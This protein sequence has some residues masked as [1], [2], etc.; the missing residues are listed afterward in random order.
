VVFYLNHSLEHLMQRRD[1]LVSAGAVSAL[2][3]GSARA[4]LETAKLVV[5]YAP[6]TATDGLA[7]TL[8]ERMRGSY[9]GNFVVENKVG[10]SGQMA[11]TAV[12]SAQ[13]DG[14]TILVSPIMVLSVVPHT[15]AKV[16]FDPLKDLTPIGNS[17]TT[18]F[19]LA[20]GPAVP[21]SIKTIA[22]YAQ[23]CKANPSKASYGTGGTGTKIHF[24]GVRFS[25]LAGFDY[26]HIGYTANS[27][28]LTDLASGALPAYIGSVATVLPFQNRI[29]ILG[30]M[31]AKRSR[32]LPSVPTFV[33]SGFKDMLIDEAISLYL[34]SRTP[35]PIVQRL[36][37][38]MIAALSTAEASATLNTLGLEASPSTPAEFA[39]KLKVEHEL[40]GRFVKQIGF[41]QD[42]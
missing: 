32:F 37:T 14:K 40:W 26:T 18:D 19:V 30:T 38:A 5:G 29:R 12:K 23:W 31:G 20:V 1:F 28:A 17:V 24:A 22:Q 16:D 35:E 36:H 6:G 41:K 2:L 7:R 11:V 8:G 15:F 10:A 33:E 13:P 4:E 9:A 3:S 34:P 27:V 21:D 39:A 42:S 25:Q